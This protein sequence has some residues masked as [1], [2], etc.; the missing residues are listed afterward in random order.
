[1]VL[2]CIPSNFG[3]VKFSWKLCG[4]VWFPIWFGVDEFGLLWLS[5]V[6]FAVVDF[7]LVWNLQWSSYLS[8]HFLAGKHKKHV[9]LCY[10]AKK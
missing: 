8:I 6:W 2:L 5:S 9:F 3:L 4:L 1:M 7:C 10:P